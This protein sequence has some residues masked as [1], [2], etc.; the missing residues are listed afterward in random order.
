MVILV[1]DGID[2]DSYFKLHNINEGVIVIWQSF[3]NVF[4]LALYWLSLTL[5]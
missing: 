3:H 1:I 2:I 4:L 5:K